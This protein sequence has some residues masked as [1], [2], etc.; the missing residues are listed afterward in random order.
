[1]GGWRAAFSC[2]RTH[3]ADS[4]P[5]CHAQ[6]CLLVQIDDAARK[7]TCYCLAHALEPN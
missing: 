1:L 4:R 3:A 6:A 7:R 2:G 5:G